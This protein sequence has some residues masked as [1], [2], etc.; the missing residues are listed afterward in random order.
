M[1]YHT[2]A[3]TCR[4]AT[5]PVASSR[6]N[7]QQHTLAPAPSL[8]VT[9]VES[10][11]H[12]YIAPFSPPPAAASSA[13]SSSVPAHRAPLP[14]PRPDQNRVGPRAVPKTAHLS[15]TCPRPRNLTTTPTLMNT[16]VPTCIDSL[17]SWLSQA[18]HSRGPSAAP[19][20][21][22]TQLQTRP[23]LDSNSQSPNLRPATDIDITL[24][25]TAPAPW[26]TQPRPPP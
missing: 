15:L 21:D 26:S 16:G 11:K 17:P 12:Y 8:T 7:P 18:R 19:A 2:A 5:T 24:L 20:L 1:P 22:G 4:C 14:H 9:A 10:S 6:A 3:Q 23:A 13:V 25:H